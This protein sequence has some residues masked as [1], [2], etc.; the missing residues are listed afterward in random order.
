MSIPARRR[1]QWHGLVIEGAWSA[2]EIGERWC[3][4]FAARPLTE[5]TPDL[6]VELSLVEQVPAAPGAAP[7]FKQ[8]DLLA[9]YVQAPAVLA[10]FPR[11]GQ[12]QLNLAQGTTR[13]VL[14]SAALASY[15]VFEDLLAIGLSPHLR[16]HGQFLLHA[17]AAAPAADRPAVLI[18]GDIGAGKTTTGLALL[19]AGW[20]LLSNDSP[21]I[22]DAPGAVGVLSYPGL[23][24]AYPDTL[25]RFAELARLIPASREREKTIFAAEAVYPNVWLDSAPG[26]LRGL[27]P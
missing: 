11:Y 7:D 25:D 13:G 16:R 1:W 10:H 15:G 17:F 8:G 22:T 9:Y 27:A 21:I 18:A 12:L 20:K 19:H 26:G 3:A 4:T 6:S 24:S 5:A 14:T 2:P 23:L